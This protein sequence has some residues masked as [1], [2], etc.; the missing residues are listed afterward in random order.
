MNNL[1]QQI[2]EKLYHSKFPSKL[3]RKNSQPLSHYI[4]TFGYVLKTGIAWRDLRTPLH[5]STYYKK[6]K[7][8]VDYGL[9]QLLHM[10]MIKLA[11]QK[12]LLT[13]D[14]LK[15]LFID[16]TMIKNFKGIDLV[17]KNHYDRNRL[18]NKISLVISS[19]G[20]PLSISLT[21]ANIHDLHQVIPTINNMPIKIKSTNLVADGAYVSKS[22]KANLRTRKI[23]LI[24]H[25]RK[26]QKLKNTKKELQMLKKRY[27]VENVFSW[28]QNYRRL[29]IRYEKSSLT[30]LQFYYFGLAEVISRKINKS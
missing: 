8:W 1:T 4:E 13:K 15:T 2:L 21:T 30:Y 9:F 27:L 14:Q 29:K 7:T 18:G 25:Y 10:S 24:S 28:I 17:G 5:W 6:F 3:G 23:K 19:N 16:S 11:E 12:K 22:L 20:I 26:N